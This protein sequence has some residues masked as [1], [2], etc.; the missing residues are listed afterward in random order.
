[1][2]III[3]DN[4]KL[5]ITEIRRQVLSVMPYAQCVCFTKQREAI[6]YLRENPVDVALLDVD[7]FANY[8]AA[9]LYL[10]NDDWPNNNVKAYRSLDDGRFRFIC[11]DLDYS[12]NEWGQTIASALDGYS[13]VKMVKLFKNLLEHDGFR[14][15]FIDT[16]CIMAGSVF[17]KERVSVIVDELA[18]AMRPNSQYDGKLPDN[19]ANKIK[20][21]LK[22]RLPNL[23]DQLQ[24]YKPMQLSGVQKQS[25]RISADVSGAT[26]FMNGIKVPYADF[27]GQ[28]FDPV[29]LEAQAPAGYRFVRWEKGGSIYSRKSVVNLPKNSSFSMKA[30]FEPLT[31]GERKDQGIT[32]VRINEVSAANSI[33]VNEFFKR[34]DWVELYNTTDQ[35]IDVEGMY[36]SDNADNSKKYQIS[37]AN[38]LST[39]IPARGYLIIW[40]DKLDPLSQLHA[41]FK[42]AAEGDELLLTAADDSWTDRFTYT[43]M[44]GDETIGRYPDGSNSVI[45]MNVP[46]IAKTNIIGSYAIVVSQP[47]PVGI[48]DVVAQQ[49][50]QPTY[51]L[52]G[53]VVL[54]GLKPGIYIRNGHKIVIK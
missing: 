8:M 18:D 52:S 32:P 44:K 47:D 6:E 15:K 26:I 33:Y 42:L 4:H 2:N 30:R 39:L 12:F 20:N 45:T 7:E 54:G 27:N 28:L 25:V 1:M 21:K 41:P 50:S 43:A 53:Q 29:Q 9:E 49:A 3:L 19:S 16:F 34:N 38:G 13:S 48:S 40:C 51:N 17:E 11:F 23:I 37:K 35:D 14:R 5:I 46:T 24:K 36:L 10:G 22:D 31:D